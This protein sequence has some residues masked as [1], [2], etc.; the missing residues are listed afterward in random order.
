MIQE[1]GKLQTALKPKTG[2]FTET[3]KLETVLLRKQGTEFDK[4]TDVANT[5]MCRDYKGA[6]NQDFNFVIEKNE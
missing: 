4:Y 2:V 3:S 6:G 5:I 1:S